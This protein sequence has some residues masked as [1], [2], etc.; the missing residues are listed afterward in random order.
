LVK[1]THIPDDIGLQFVAAVSS[2][3]EHSEKM[4]KKLKMMGSAI[5]LGITKL[6]TDVVQSQ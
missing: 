5:T 3:H 4:K 1:G 2:Y 6:L